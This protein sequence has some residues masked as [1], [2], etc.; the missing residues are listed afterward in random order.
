M[1]S[2]KDWFRFAESIMEGRSLSESEA[3]ELAAVSGSDLSEMMAA[4]NAV[5]KFF[6][7]DRVHTCT[8]LNAKSGKCSENCRFCAQ[9]H[10]AKTD[11]PVY[12]LVGEEV[13][14]EH[15]FQA[16]AAGVDRF[17]VVTSGRALPMAEVKKIAETFASQKS[18]HTCFCASL[19]ILSKEAL[20][21]LFDAGVTRYHHNLETARSLFPEICTT[22]TYDERIQTVKD[23]KDVG[24][25]VC[26]G[27][28]FGIGETD[29]QVVEMALEIRSLEADA[30]PV[31]FLLPVPGTA[32]ENQKRISPER[33][34][35]VLSLFRLINPKAEILVCGGRESALGEL[36][37]LIFSAGASGIM[38]G[39]YL[40]RTGRTLSA[41]RKML[42]DLG[43]SH[44]LNA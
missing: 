37:P 35:K 26:V 14:Y 40:T 38:T 15:A 6:R 25:S 29:E 11:S 9:S 20:K 19:G 10:V 3:Y 7:K 27:G 1:R 42:N 24:M 21:I 12:G 41:D 2:R 18:H 4:A 23:A 44:S 30:I 13:I 32:M 36:H 28:I 31:N 34:F 17:A 5:R 39:N 22:H 16:D 8:I 43:F 33:C